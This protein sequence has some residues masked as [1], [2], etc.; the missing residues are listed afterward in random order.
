[1]REKR[2]Y[3]PIASLQ[4]FAEEAGDT[5]VTG[6]AAQSQPSGEEIPSDAGMENTEAAFEE[7]IRGKYKK[8]F[9]DRV[10]TIIRKRLS[11]TRET[12]QKMRTLE[13]A[14]ALLGRKYGLDPSDVEG[15]SRAVSADDSIYAAEAREKGTTVDQLRQLD[16][17]RSENEA[18]RR[19]ILMDGA[20]RLYQSWMTEAEQVKQ[21]YPEFD[22]AS[23]MQNPKFRNLLRS[24]V[25]IR[26]AYEVVNRDTI[27]P[28]VVAQAQ[29]NTERRITNAILS[30]R[31][32]LENG[33]GEG[34]AALVRPDVT[35]LS[36]KELRD[37]Q[38]RVGSGER[39]SFG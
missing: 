25:D 23:Q 37:I 10:S 17:A 2:T 28:T 18:L 34:S 32:P 9:D 12:A 24:R 1:M 7:L 13:P 21:E 26:T 4:L 8:N 38:R 14:L 6:T 36:A 22:F 30:R 20:G 33:L 29:R 19:R 11:S 3:V 27:I 39:I 5:G 31:L 35:K 16:R 15:I